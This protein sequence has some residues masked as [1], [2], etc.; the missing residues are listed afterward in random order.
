MKKWPDIDDVKGLTIEQIL[1]HP[2]F[3]DGKPTDEEI[4]Y[5][6]NCTISEVRAARR[7]LAAKKG[8]A[9]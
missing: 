2:L 9:A 5:S 7:A 3:I 1:T 4:A 8:R 6:A